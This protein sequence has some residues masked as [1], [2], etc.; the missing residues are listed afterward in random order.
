MKKNVTIEITFS[1]DSLNS[2]NE[3]RSINGLKGI[4]GEKVKVKNVKVEEKDTEV[5]EGTTVQ[6]VK[7]LIYNLTNA[8]DVQWREFTNF[9]DKIGIEAARAEY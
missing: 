9:E 5:E 3:V 2:V 4:N 7:S 6:E 8:K 1:A